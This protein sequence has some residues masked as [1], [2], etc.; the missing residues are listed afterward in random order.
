MLAVLLPAPRR[1]TLAPSDEAAEPTTGV[2]AWESPA[3]TKDNNKKKPT[4]AAAAAA[5]PTPKLLSRPS[6]HSSFNVDDILSRAELSQKTPITNKAEIAMHKELAR[7]PCP[8]ISEFRKKDRLS[9]MGC[10]W[11]KELKSW[12]TTSLNIAREHR[13]VIIFDDGF[14]PPRCAG[15]PRP[16]SSCSCA[17]ALPAFSTV[18]WLGS[19][20]AAC[21][22]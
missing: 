12:T 19:P 18:D 3:Q 21:W 22:L 15:M 8:I 4:G 10:R 16:S 1:K 7:R 20:T 11:D 13:D 9:A 6:P 5:A 14:L 17:A 2:D